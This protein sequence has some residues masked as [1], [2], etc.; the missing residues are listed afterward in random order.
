MSFDSRS[1]A[2]MELL[3]ELA[4]HRYV[5]VGGYA[6]SAFNTRFST[7]LDVVIAPS[8]RDRLMDFLDDRGFKQRE[9]HRKRWVYETEVI[10][11]EKRLGPR[12]PVGFDLLVNGLG[13]RQTEA[14]WSFEYLSAHSTTREVSGGTRTVTASVVDGP[15][16]AATKLHSG[17]ETD[18]RDVLAI[19]AEVD[20]DAV[21]P[22]L[23]RGDEEKLRAQLERGR[24][25]L[26]GDEF[27]HGFRS[28]FGVSTVSSE[29]V[30]AL[31]SYLSGQ[32]AQLR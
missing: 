27:E 8:E 15:V 5:L 17:R 29:T 21:T 7:D 30:T 28:E 18:L 26:D 11:Y 6:V 23:R 14:Q 19:A 32:I 4:D 12:Q 25:I 1:N 31:Q 16:L 13:C 22:H 3:D 20:L 10:Q 24:D 9:S 2:L